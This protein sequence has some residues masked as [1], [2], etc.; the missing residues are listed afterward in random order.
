MW[1]LVNGQIDAQLPNWRTILFCVFVS[2][3]YMFR[4]TPCSSSGESIVSIQPPAYITL[5]LW[6]FVVQVHSYFS[7]ISKAILALG[8]ARSLRE[9]NRDCRGADRPGWCDALPPKKILH[10]SCRMGRR[11]VLMRLI[12]LLGHCEC[13]G[14][15]EHKLNQRR[16]TA[17][18]LAPRESDCKRMNSKVSSD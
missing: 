2:I 12:C 17:D 14:H 16:L 5:C 13:D 8:K 11:I 1:F 3:L 15:T 7:S 4:A 18:W 6:P 9:P 10:E